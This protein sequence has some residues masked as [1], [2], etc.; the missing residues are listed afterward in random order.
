VATWNEWHG[1]ECFGPRLLT[2]ALPALFFFL[3]ETLAAW[4]YAGA[5]LAAISVAIQL[6][7]GWT[8]DYRWERLHQRG[9]EFEAA[10]WSWPES[11]IAFAVREGVLIQGTPSAEGRRLRLQLRRF[12]PFGPEGS[13]VEATASGLRIG[14]SALVHHVRL[15]RGA[16]I[17]DGRITLTHPGDALAFRSESAGIRTVRIVGSSPQDAAPGGSDQAVLR[18]ETPAGSKSVS[19]AGDFDLRLDLPLG[20]DEDAFVRAE[21]GELRITRLDF[22]GD[23]VRP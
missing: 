3:P 22:G 12:V 1:G 13:T 21:S 9:R 11:P 16:R 15:E 14:G 4:P 10:L 19:V 7:G 5:A 23:L 20:V 2:D 8:Y 17:T 18:L 6:L